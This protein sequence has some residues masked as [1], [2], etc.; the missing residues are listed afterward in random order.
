MKIVVANSVGV[1][2]GGYHMVHVPSRWSLGIKNFTN[3]GYYPWQLAYTSSLLKRETDHQIK[4]LDGVL[5]G[6][7]FETYFSQLEKERPDWLIMESSSRTIDEDLRLASAAKKAFGTKLIFTGQHPMAQPEEVL[8]TADYVCMGEY[9]YSVLELIEGKDPK[10]ISGVYPNDRSRL[11]DIDSLPF[12]EDE[13][14]KRI[15]YHEP[16][17]RYRQIQMYASRGCPRRC[18]FC[19]AA[20]LYYDELNWRPR[21]VDDVVEEIRQL[22][23]KYPEMEGVFFDEEVHNIKRSF[24]IALSKAIREADLNHLKYEALCEYVSLDEEA[25]IEMRKAGYYKIRFGIETASDVIAGKMTLGKKH[26]P[27]KL[28]SI[29]K[30]GKGIGF[31]FYATFSVGGLGSNEEEDQKTVDMIFELTRQGLLDEVQVSINTPQPGTDFYNTC[32]E[33]S[34]LK[35]GIEW[36]DFDGNGHVVVDYPNYPAKDIQK[37]FNKA[38]EAFDRGKAVANSSRFLV[39]A[40]AS[41]SIIPDNSRVL[42]LRSARQ[43]MIHLILKTLGPLPHAT[44]DLLGQDAVMDDFHGTQYVNNL[45]TYGQGF[46]SADTFPPKLAD[47]LRANDY[48]I[49]LVPL[50]NNHLQGY[51][52]VLEVAELFHPKQ[53]LGVYPEGDFK[54]LTLSPE[55]NEIVCNTTL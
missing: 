53:L 15:D 55:K 2:A 23:E 12:P 49:V 50:A 25:L 5:N 36:Q 34:Y 7:D 39:T 22:K 41:S 45:Y 31:V 43:W 16:N 10:Y 46:F 20:T 44:L 17:C 37:M 51:E 6:W 4:F 11:L 18:N 40:K 32:V 54:E 21:N 33:N 13:D 52:N 35:T 19:A 9:E 30:F 3:C 29:L 42:V 28:R 1:D 47:Q 48:D 8:K 38:L 26:A 24:N 27:D 14:I